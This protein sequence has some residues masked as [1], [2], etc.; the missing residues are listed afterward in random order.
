MGT[1]PKIAEEQT[2]YMEAQ[3]CERWVREWQSHFRSSCTS[4]RGDANPRLHLQQPSGS[5]EHPPTPTA[6]PVAISVRVCLDAAAIEAP[7]PSRIVAHSPHRSHVWQRGQ[8]P[9]TSS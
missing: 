4:G 6:E 8:C 1:M 3:E 2:G 5:R 9:F 7:E